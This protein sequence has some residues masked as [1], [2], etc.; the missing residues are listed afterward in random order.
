MSPVAVAVAVAV[1]VLGRSLGGLRPFLCSLCG[2]GGGGGGR[3]RGRRGGGGGGGVRVR[4]P[5]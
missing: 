1:A 4:R 3:R 5:G 2:G